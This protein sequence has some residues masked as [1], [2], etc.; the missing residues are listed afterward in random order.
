MLSRRIAQ[1]LLS[2]NVSVD[3]VISYLKEHKLTSLFP[4]VMRHMKGAAVREKAHNT[5]IIES[6]FP[7]DKEAVN[8]IKK[9]IGEEV[10]GVEEKENKDLL[11]GF[12][13][14]FKDKEYDASARTILKTFIHNS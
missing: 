5:L 7:L 13:A 2:G 3:G 1:L 10:A 8:A 6:P 11:A 14:K 12:T 4:H 9:R